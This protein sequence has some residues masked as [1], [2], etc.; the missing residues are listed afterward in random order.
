M[1]QQFLVKM[2]QAWVWSWVIFPVRGSVPR[3]AV[4]IQA[5][6]VFEFPPWVWHTTISLSPYPST[7]GDDKPGLSLSPRLAS[8]SVFTLSL[9]QSWGE[10]QNLDCHAAQET[11]SLPKAVKNLPTQPELLFSAPFS[12][13][14]LAHPTQWLCS[15]HRAE[16][17]PKLEW[18]RS[19]IQP[20]GPAIWKTS[21]RSLTSGTTKQTY[22]SPWGQP[23]L[24]H[25]FLGM[26]MWF[27]SGEFWKFRLFK[28]LWERR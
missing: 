18:P 8:L 23:S 28:Q 9:P 2:S 1:L 13:A 22:P 11:A 16:T 19:G 7:V 27:T 21:W 6:P 17:G 25:E 14:F 24:M 3:E 10:V 12:T 5:G 20:W 26:A 15:V 4:S